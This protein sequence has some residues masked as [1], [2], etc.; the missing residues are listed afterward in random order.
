MITAM[1]LI[2]VLVQSKVFYILA[3][4]YVQNQLKFKII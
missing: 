2:V 3:Y 4:I 1:H